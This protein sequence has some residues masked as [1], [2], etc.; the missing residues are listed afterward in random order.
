[1]A[2]GNSL[3]RELIAAFAVVFAGAVVV[4]VTGAILLTPTF[5][6]PLRAVLYL[7]VLL[8]ADLVVF[9]FFGR[10]LIRTRVLFPLDR[11]VEEAEAIAAGDYA[12]RLPRAGAEEIDRLSDS[13]NGMAERLINHQLEL[14]RNVQSL[15]ETNRDLTEARDDLIRAEKM[16]SLGQMAAGV[17]HEI[18]NP[19]AA[20]VGNVDLLKRRAEG[21]EL[22]IV[23]S[24]SEQAHRIDRIVRSL[25]DYSRVREA[26]A[27]PIDVN[28]VVQ[29]TL[30]LV[31]AQRR[32][33]GVEVETALDDTLPAVTAD[34]YQL[35]QV[36]VNLFLN[37]ADAM[38]NTEHPTVCVRSSHHVYERASYM[39]ARRADDPPGIDYSHRRRFNRP[40]RVPRAQPFE[41]GVHI[42]EITV[43]DSG[44]G[45]PPDVIG[46][47]FEPFMTT[48]EPGKGTGLGLAVSARLIDGMSGTIQASNGEHGARF[49]VLLPASE[50]PA[51]AHGP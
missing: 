50:E 13:L 2:A 34:P 38:A 7:L 31:A 4:A 35:E 49:K 23:E 41:P 12:R 24:T 16:A 15:E 29:K 14:A 44:P 51:E 48:K 28:A 43:E 27:R 9:F 37:A 5:A 42:V 20:I 22:Q 32:F 19:L 1:M 3:R 36:L 33:A 11:M 8:A 30:E 47:I 45:I 10:W 25:L 18:G 17:A 6:T 39:P 46:R 40:D 26:R 21:R